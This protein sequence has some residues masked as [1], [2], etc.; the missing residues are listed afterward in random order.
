MAFVLDVTKTAATE[1][2]TANTLTFD[3]WFSAADGL[4]AGDYIMVVCSN[5]TGTATALE[6]TSATGSWTKLDS[7][8]SPRVGTFMRSQIWWHKY[9]GTTLPTEPT[10]SNGAS[11]AWAGVAWVCA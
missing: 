1:G 7:T 10:A 2:V 8:D 9:D 6:L 5:Q 4:L 11:T 3:D